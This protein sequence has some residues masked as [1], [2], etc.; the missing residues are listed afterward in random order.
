M[1]TGAAQCSGTSLPQCQGVSYTVLLAWLLL[2]VGR[3]MAVVGDPLDDVMPPELLV[4][5]LG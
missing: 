3:P 4:T 1:E 2:A 5:E